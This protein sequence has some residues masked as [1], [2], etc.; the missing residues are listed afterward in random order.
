MKVLE[1]FAGERC[2]GRAFENRGHEV[3]SVDW[4]NR[5]K[6]INLVQD[7]NKVSANDILYK[8]GKPD[9]IW[10]SPDCTSYSVAAISKHRRKN[11]QTGNLDPISDYARFCDS[12]NIHVLELIKD[13]QPKFY[14]IENPRGALRNMFFMQ[15]L[16]RY[17][18]TYCQYGDERQKP[19]D[20]FTNHPNPNFLPTCK[21]GDRCHIAA[22]RGSV[23]GTQGRKGSVQRSLIPSKLC[24][25]IVSICERYIDIDSKFD[26][27]FIKENLSEQLSL[28]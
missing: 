25:H 6:N 28:F 1:L 10:A 3:F 23:T 13:L 9:I 4:D 18:V 2:I 14:F 27:K 12:T 19:T 11:K 20:I 15:S 22:P 7:I 26:L 16:K 21:S 24:E 17:T 8:F 5:H